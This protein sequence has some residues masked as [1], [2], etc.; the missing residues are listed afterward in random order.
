METVNTNDAALQEKL[1]FD[2]FRQEVLKDYRICCESRETSLVGRK[3][4]L[5]GKAKFGIFGD[6]KEV[7]QVAVAKFF[8]PGDFRAGYYRDQT[9]MMAAGI[10]NAEQY[11]A[12]LFSDPDINN[13]PF[14]AGRQM[15]AHFATKNVDANGEW[16]DLANTKNS[17]S[18]M[19]PT[20]GQMPRALGLAL[21]SKLF[22]NADIFK[23]HTNL[24]DNG[25]E[26]CF[27]T[28][29]DASTS[30]GHFWEVV[31]AA[32][33][34]QVPLAIFI[35]DD[36]YGISVPKQLQTT[37][38]SISA[39]LS[40]MQKT[41]GT[42]GLDIYNLKG[43]DYAGMCE[44]FEPAIQKIRETHIPAIFH[45]EEITQPQGHSTSGSHERYKKPERLAWE[46]EWDC[47]KQ[48]RE[49]ILQ[50]ALAEDYELSDI[51]MNA[52]LLIKNSKQK[53][54]DKYIAPI[55]EQVTSA[56][57]LL[58]NLAEKLDAES[59]AKVKKIVFELTANKEPLRREV[60]KAIATTLDIAANDDAAKELDVFYKELRNA[61][62]KL[63]NSFLYN[64][65]PKSALN[66]TVIKPYYS[67]DENV[68]N[69]YEVLN[70]YFD[71]LFASNDKVTA[72]GE[73]VGYIGDVNQGFSGLQAKY[74]VQR[75]FD[76]GIRELSIMGQGIGLAL[77]GLRPIAE[78]QY[79]DYLLYGLQT[80]SDD[81]ATTHFRTAG[82]QSCP[83]IIRTRGHRLEGIWHSG[84]P[85]GMII[86]SIRGIYVCVPRN[87]VQAAGMYN[88]LLQSNDPALMIECLNGYRLK[89][90]LPDNLLAFTVPLGIP[91]T[92]KEGTDVTIVTYGSTIRIVQE[93]AVNLDKLGVSCEIIDV[94]TL[95]PFDIH[96]AIV[97]SLKKTNRIIFADEDVPGGA[98]AYMFNKVMEEQ[99]GYKYLDAAPRTITGQAH[100]PSYASDGDYFSKPNVEDVVRIVKEMM[101]E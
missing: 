8:K 71:A 29:G 50:N 16:L 55:K 57:L 21:A 81:L 7:A 69:G 74:G 45:I 97:T 33:V 2:H 89:E 53:A 98:A 48:M 9:F 52:K 39:A 4:V 51:E 72:F 24:S 10:A 54:W 88:T 18:D 66:V 95:L 43:W 15:N 58:N 100:R 91:E 6:G 35:W 83:L 49:W 27:C 101:A 65:G 28:I 77:R 60:L 67:N 75:I 46:K 62:S 20:A 34:Q 82:Q 23:Q 47:I 17:S 1:S 93:A 59:G 70:K 19:A 37:K 14:S 13:D 86:N 84:S 76:T 61:N 85:M 64:E 73:D 42:N 87:M 96:H 36:G 30:E 26:V 44:V 94:Q 56:V 92:L 3:E 32:G 68:V 80:L 90:K 41:E 31:N 40:G 11:F 79:I 25:N 63:Y 38:G 99:G 12:Q 78:I 22:R 5:T